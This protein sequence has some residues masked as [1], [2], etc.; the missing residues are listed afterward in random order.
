[1][2]L[3]L[4]LVLHLINKE[5]TMTQ[6]EMTQRIAVPKTA[7]TLELVMAQAAQA[8]EMVQ[9][10]MAP[11]TTL[12]IAATTPRLYGILPGMN[13]WCLVTGRASV[14]TMSLSGVRER[15]G[16][17]NAENAGLK[18]QNQSINTKM[19]Q[20]TGDSLDQW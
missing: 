11:E 1:M 3:D 15:F 14:S 4:I 9:A 16:A 20:D 7:K 6:A 12:A 18:R 10:I 5:M 2:V 13:G 19:K 17:S 8:L